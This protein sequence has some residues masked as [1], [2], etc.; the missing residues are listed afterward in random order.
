[1]SA[2][3]EQL[4]RRTILLAWLAMV[5]SACVQLAGYD[6]KAYENATSL[7][8]ATLAMVGKSAKSDSFTAKE[9]AIDNLLVRL[10]AAYEYANGIE[11]NN[12][13]AKNWRDLIGND[14]SMIRGWLALW[15]SSGSVSKAF[16]T[17][18]REQIAE[19]FD[20]IICL[21]ANKRQLSSCKSLKRSE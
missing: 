6:Q 14:E 21:E 8:A 9:A 3:H 16:M 7:K 13:A 19:G 10:N 15:R 17:E 2:K 12:E 18:I 4:V 5:A 20:T 1:M 11:Y